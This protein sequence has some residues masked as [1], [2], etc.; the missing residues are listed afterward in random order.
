MQLVLRYFLRLQHD[1]TRV[2]RQ[3]TLDEHDAQSLAQIR[4]GFGIGIRL[5]AQR[6][7]RYGGPRISLVFTAGMLAPWLGGR[8]CTMAMVVMFLAIEA[9][10]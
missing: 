10:S 3:N 7:I 2:G 6:G 9:Q 1:L 8:K 5:R 4:V